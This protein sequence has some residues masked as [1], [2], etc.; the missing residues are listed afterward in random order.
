[1][2][3]SG[4]DCEICRG[5]GMAKVDAFGFGSDLHHGLARVVDFPGDLPGPVLRARDGLDQLLHHVFEGVTVAVV[6]NG[7]PGRREGDV[8]LL[9]LLDFRSRLRTGE[10]GPSPHLPMTPSALSRAMVWRP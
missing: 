3:R 2:R 5:A 6:E 8:D 4:G 10:R 7:D 9:G 1:M